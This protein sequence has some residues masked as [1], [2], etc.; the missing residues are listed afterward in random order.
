MNDPRA[1]DL[2][3]L[4]EDRVQELASG[5]GGLVLLTPDER[6]RHH[7]LRAGCRR[8]FLGGRLLCRLALSARTG[9]PP[10]TWRFVRTG[11]GRPELAADHD[12][13]RFNVSHTD[14]LIVCAVVR[15]RGCGVD[16]ERVPFDD[17]KATRLNALLDGPSDAEAEARADADARGLGVAV[18]ERWVL[19]EAYLK[20]LGVGL[21]DGL[22]DLA[23]RRHGDGRFT[24][25]DHLRPAL[26]ARWE[27]ALLRPSPHHL[28]AVA[29]EDGGPLRWRPVPPMH[30]MH[31]MHR[32]QPVQATPYR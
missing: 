32:I 12:G 16:V 28:V 25:T 18:S 31:P 7:R 8:R 11:H 29:T 30:P 21:A 23:F 19:T 10:A 4:P 9:L 2:W 17:D 1:V 15:G 3:T 13:L 27:L 6:A 24:V 22:P 20:G 14:G 5:M 26:A